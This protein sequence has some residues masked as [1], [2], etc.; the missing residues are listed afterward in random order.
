MYL[1]LH[2]ATSGVI[3]LYIVTEVSSCFSVLQCTYILADIKYCSCF[4]ESLAFIDT[5]YQLVQDTKLL[6]T[7]VKDL[8]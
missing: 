6:A 5:F 7:A 8:H 4:H 1:T 3:H 2:C